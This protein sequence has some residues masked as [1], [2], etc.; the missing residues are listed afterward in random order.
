MG[1]HAVRINQPWKRKSTGTWYVCLNGKQRCLGAD[2]DQAYEEFR[3]MTQSGVTTNYT[4]SARYPGVLG[5]GTAAPLA[6]Q[7]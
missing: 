4:L 3:R 1:V 5:V 7:R 2:K 6:S